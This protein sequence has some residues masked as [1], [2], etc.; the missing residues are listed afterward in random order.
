MARPT[1]ALL[2]Q[3]DALGLAQHAPERRDCRRLSL[4]I[5]AQPKPDTTTDRQWSLDEIA[6]ELRRRSEQV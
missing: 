2:R 4:W 5:A 1:A 6:A 3:A